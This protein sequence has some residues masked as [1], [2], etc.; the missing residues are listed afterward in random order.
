MPILF[1]DNNFLGCVF[2]FGLYGTLVFEC[3]CRVFVNKKCFFKISNQHEV[4]E[5][6][7]GVKCQQLWHIMVSNWHVVAL[8]TQY[9]FC[10]FVYCLSPRFWSKLFCSYHICKSN[11]L[12]AFCLKTVTSIRET[13]FTLNRRFP[14]ICIFTLYHRQH[15][16]IVIID[17]NTLVPAIEKIFLV[18]YKKYFNTIPLLDNKVETC[19]YNFAYC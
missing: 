12:F 13:E 5:E 19:D 17:K 10:T 9:G 11:L 6:P 8:H 3:L 7:L 4:H 18:T 1:W 2:Y 16:F 14:E 15:R